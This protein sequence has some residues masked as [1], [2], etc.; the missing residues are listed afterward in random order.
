MP[1]TASRGGLAAAKEFLKASFAATTEFQRICPTG[2]AS[3]HV[4]IDAIPDP[5]GEDYTPAEIGAYRPFVLISANS[6]RRFKVGSGSFDDAGKLCAVLEVE[7]E[8]L[9]GDGET[10]ESVEDAELERRLENIMG[11]II[12]REDDN[13]T[14]NTIESLADEGGYFAVEESY[15]EAVY[16]GE[17]DL[18]PTQGDFMRAQYIFGWNGGRA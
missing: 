7:T 16:R 11:A 9:L 5:K 1:L 13:D 14:S 6:Y 4:H 8:S 12:S 10:L 15:P 18:K 2:E 17:V 3:D